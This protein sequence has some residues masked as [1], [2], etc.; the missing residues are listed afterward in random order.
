MDNRFYGKI[1]TAIFFVILLL[2]IF[3][4]VLKVKNTKK[5]KMNGI[6]IAML[7]LFLLLIIDY[8]SDFI[9]YNYLD[10][11]LKKDAPVLAGCEER[12]Y[13]DAILAGVSEELVLRLIVFNVILIKFC[14]LSINKSIIISAVLFG[15]THI[16]QY[17]SYGTNIYSTLA[18]IISS[19]PAGLILAYV[20]ANTNLTTAIVIH[21]LLDFIDFIFLRCNKTL[22]S[23]M[24]FIND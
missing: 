7:G 4:D 10:D 3:T 6:M 23:K 12:S 18:T 21:F 5:V 13:Y 22:Y 17:I 24:L 14:K 16:N 20:Y 9:T 8:A 2:D 1:A 15:L 11:Y 19:I